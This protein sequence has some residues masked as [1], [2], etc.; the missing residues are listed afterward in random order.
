MNMNKTQPGLRAAMLAWALTIAS[1][2]STTAAAA[3]ND[4]DGFVLSKFEGD[5]SLA[6]VQKKGEL[7]IGTSND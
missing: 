7:V 4:A 1:L 6:R 3:P 5:G 2:A